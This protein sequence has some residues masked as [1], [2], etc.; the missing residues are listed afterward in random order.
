M[1]LLDRVKERVETDLSDAE[2]QAMID[3]VEDEIDVRFGPAGATSRQLDGDRR[4]L[5]LLDRADV[6]KPITVVEVA[7]REL[8][9]AANETTLSADDYR[10]LHDGRTFERLADGTNGR[11]LWAPLVKLT[12]TPASKARQRDEVIIKV[13][14]L[15]LSYR[16]LDK[17]ASNGDVSSGGNMAA[18]AYTSE[19]DA[20][21]DQL[22][23][24]PGL[25][26]A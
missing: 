8:G 2:L 21:L 9:D 10:V 12:Y 22:S 6:S 17:Q 5:S 4:F 3:Q 18:D 25:V 24:R 20:L 1:T 19:R 16:G 15:D 7:A 14:Q 23:P 11:L 13:V 26:L